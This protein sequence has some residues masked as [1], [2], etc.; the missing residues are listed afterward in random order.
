MIS[1]LARSSANETDDAYGAVVAKLNTR[2]R[3]SR[4][5][6]DI[7]WIL[8]RRKGW[9]GAAPRWTG[10]SYFRTREALMGVTHAKAG[11]CDPIAWSAL[12]ALPERY[13][14]ADIPIDNLQTEEVFE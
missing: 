8:Q 5:R 4:C 2:W 9:T 7:Q 11:D 13:E 6:D 10:D 12:L 3:V 14:P 1:H